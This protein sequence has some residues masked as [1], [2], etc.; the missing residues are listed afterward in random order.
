MGLH[1][2]GAFVGYCRKI[3]RTIEFNEFEP[4]AGPEGCKHMGGVTFPGGGGRTAFLGG[5]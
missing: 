2:A 3:H 5:V 4:A 1:K